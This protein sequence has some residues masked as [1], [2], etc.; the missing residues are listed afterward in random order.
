MASG[1]VIVS[2]IGF[3]IL[4]VEVIKDFLLSEENLLVN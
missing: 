1:A 3:N 2:L 4:L